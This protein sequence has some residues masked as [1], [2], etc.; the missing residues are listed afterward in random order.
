MQISCLFHD[1]LITVFHPPNF[2]SKEPEDDENESQVEQGETY[3]EES[4]GTTFCLYEAAVFHHGSKIEIKNIFNDVVRTEIYAFTPV[5][6]I[7]L[8]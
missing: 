6:C 8:N 3:A 7:T 4:E 5:V 2:S 1:F